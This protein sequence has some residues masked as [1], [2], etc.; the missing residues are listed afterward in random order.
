MGITNTKRLK[1][2][3]GKQMVFFAFVAA[4]TV[5]EK[6]PEQQT[7]SDILPVFTM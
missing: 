4:M 3:A 5:Y 6:I 1:L 7:S 2:R